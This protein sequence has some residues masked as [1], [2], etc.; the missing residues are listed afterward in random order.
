MS[1]GTRQYPTKEHWTRTSGLHWATAL[2]AREHRAGDLEQY[3]EWLCPCRS[4][5]A[6]RTVLHEQTGG[7]RGEP[8]QRGAR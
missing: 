6:A 3:G 8:A 7:S 1:E 5:G 2:I 4:C